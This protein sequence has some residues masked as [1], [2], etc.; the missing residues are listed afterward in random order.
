MAYPCGIS[1][2]HMY[3]QWSDFGK[4][5]QRNRGQAWATLNPTKKKHLLE[6][7]ITMTMK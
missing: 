2:V 7:H 4:V 3:V 6:S 5:S 1:L